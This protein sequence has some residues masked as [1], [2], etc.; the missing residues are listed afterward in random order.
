MVKEEA[1]S[2]ETAPLLLFRS[3][4]LAEFDLDVLGLGR[5][6]GLFHILLRDATTAKLN[7]WQVL[8]NEVMR[9]D[10]GA[11]HFDL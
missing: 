6:D 11:I 1:R 3:S 4:F 10:Y 2:R 5:S 8:G 9:L 7:A